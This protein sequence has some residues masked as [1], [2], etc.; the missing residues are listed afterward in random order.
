MLDAYEEVLHG[1]LKAIAA[2][3]EYRHFARLERDGNFP[4]V[5]ARGFSPDFRKFYAGA[6]LHAQT[7]IDFVGDAVVWCSNDYLGMGQSEIVKAAMR[8][9]IRDYGAGAGGTRN[10]AGTTILHDILEAELAD[11]HGKQAALLFGSGY[12]AN[13]AALSTLG[14]AFDDCVIFSDADNHASMIAGIRHSGAEKRIF[15]HNDPSDLERLLSA[16]RRE[17]AKIIAFESVYSMDGSVAPIGAIVDLADR[18]GALTYL[19]EVHAVGMYGAQGGGVAEREGLADCIDIIQGTLGK[20]FGVVGGYV[21]GNALSI[22]AI[23]SFAPAFIFSTALP[24]AIV[25]GAIAAVRHLRKSG[26]ERAAQR[27]NVAKVRTELS[28]A[29]IETMTNESHIVP[30]PIGDAKR[31]KALSDR[32]LKEFGI[33]LQPINYPTVPKGAERLRIT[34]SPLHTASQVKDLVA[35]LAKSAA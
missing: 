33:Y 6:D 7:S 20:A 2:S 26:A 5:T 32:L 1:K 15:R 8:D 30:L 9:A 4:A 29:G 12:A 22:D 16:E 25:A 24:P 19:D 3:G 34:P 11:L 21:A 17:R 13:E 35:A 27:A 23:R 31:C 10:I 28:A 18:F 14:R